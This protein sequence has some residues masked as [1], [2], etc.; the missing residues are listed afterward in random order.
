MDSGTRLLI[1]ILALATL[2]VVDAAWYRGYY[3]DSVVRLIA[4]WI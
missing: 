3:L 4:R 2:L 1:F